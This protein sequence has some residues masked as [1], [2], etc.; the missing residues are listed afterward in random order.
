MFLDRDIVVSLYVMIQT[1][2]VS[3]GSVENIRCT[4]KR[5]YSTVT[6]IIGRK[7]DNFNDRKS[8][9]AYFN[10]VDY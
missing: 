3:P 8:W 1:S 5:L 6:S 2:Q 4:M 7:V 10:R 9:L